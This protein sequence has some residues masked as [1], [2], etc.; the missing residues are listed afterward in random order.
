MFKRSIEARI[1]ISYGGVMFW[2]KMLKIGFTVILFLKLGFMGL[3]RDFR[4]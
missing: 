3:V 1:A 2:V 4:V